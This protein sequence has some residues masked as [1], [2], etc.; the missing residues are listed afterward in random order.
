MLTPRKE[1]RIRDEEVARK[2]ILHE[3]GDSKSRRGRL[4]TFINSPIFL[5]FLS[6][7]T[8]TAI[9][10][11][12]TYFHNRT[13]ED[14]LRQQRIAQIDLEI[15]ARLSQ[16]LVNVEPMIRKPHDPIYSLRTT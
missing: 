11:T 4:W 10:A 2:K 7:V 8:I 1:A 12:W 13:L 5:W 9:T 15:E 16:F 6:S 14:H 3:L